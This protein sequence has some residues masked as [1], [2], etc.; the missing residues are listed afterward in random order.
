MA[1]ARR[2]PAPETFLV[3]A[4]LPLVPPFKSG[5]SPK[6]K[7]GSSTP[8]PVQGGGRLRC[9]FFLPPA[10]G[11]PMPSSARSFAAASARA[12]ARSSSFLARAVSMAASHSKASIMPSP[13]VSREL[14][15]LARRSGCSKYVRLSLPQ[16]LRKSITFLSD[17]TALRISSLSSKPLWSASMRSKTARAKFRNSAENAPSASAAAR[18]RR[19]RSS[20]SCSRRLA[21]PL[22]MAV[23]HSSTSISPSCEVSNT[24]SAFCRRGGCRRNWRLGSPHVLRNV[25]TFWFDLQA[26]TISSLVNVPLASTS[27]SLKHSRAALRNSSVNASSSRR[28]AAACASRRARA[29]SSL[30]FKAVSMAL[31]HSVIVISPSPSVSTTASACAR[32]DGTQRYW[33][34]ALPQFERN[35]M[36]SFFVCTAVTTSSLTS[37]PLW[38][39]SIISKTIRALFKKSAENSSSAAAA[40]RAKLLKSTLFV[41]C[42]NAPS[43]VESPAP[44]GAKSVDICDFSRRISIAA[45]PPFDFASAS[46]F[47]PRS[48]RPISL[49]SAPRN[50]K[51]VRCGRVLNKTSNDSPSTGAFVS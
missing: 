11:P 27:M 9:F 3:W 25:T 38:S 20:A 31:S 15:A 4:L 35:S 51:T 14:S 26:W 8:P 50:L 46:S 39:S 5:M 42:S 43:Q 17:V 13:D 45:E 40:A 7:S 16:S 10:L 23:S 33:R 1:A 30:A 21:R 41:V 32:R 22:L 34:F 44:A 24:A 19:S 2:A 48:P 12:A 36:T 6:T 49:K 28:S 29:C 18:S 47:C 37:V